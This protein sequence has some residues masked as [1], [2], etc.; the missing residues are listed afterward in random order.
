M[1]FQITDKKTKLISGVIVI[2]V[3]AMTPLL[4]YLYKIVPKGT[5]SWQFLTFT[6]E[7]KGFRSVQIFIH[8]FF[9]KFTFVLSFS[10]WFLTCK[11]WWKWVLLIPLTMFLFQLTGVVNQNIEYIDEYDFWYSLP[12]TIPVLVFLIILRNRLKFYNDALDLKEQL[13]KEILELKKENLI[14][15]NNIS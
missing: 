7:T 4:F 15:Q 11:H 8:A 14:E 1:R 2:I 10:V 13:D 12:V 3:L 5:T 6:M 9:T